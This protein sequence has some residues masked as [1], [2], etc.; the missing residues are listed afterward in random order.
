M[1]AMTL[2]SHIAS[3]KP[4]SDV[5]TTLV[6][7]AN[8]ALTTSINDTLTPLVE[9]RNAGRWV[10]EVGEGAGVDLHPFGTGTAGQTY[11]G[12]LWVG[13]PI[14]LP[15]AKDKQPSQWTY[16]HLFDFNGAI[17]AVTGVA[18]GLIPATMAWA[19]V[20]IS[21]DGGLAPAK[22]RT[23]QSPLASQPGRIIADGVCAPIYVAELRI[24]TCSNI[25]LLTSTWSR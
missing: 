16:R 1:N 22:T 24:G 25:G 7:T 20:G 11:L 10:F 5:S 14:I 13:I 21:N 9:D 18:N 17:S 4:Q 19:S 8:G 23:M 6:T 15:N 12:R 3:I 2:V